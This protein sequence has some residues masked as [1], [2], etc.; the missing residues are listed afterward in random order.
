MTGCPS[1]VQLKRLLAGDLP[2]PECSALESHIQQCPPCQETL[3]HLTE[4][5]VVQ[6]GEDGPGSSQPGLL[7]LLEECQEHSTPHQCDTEP[8]PAQSAAGAGDQGLTSIASAP[9]MPGAQGRLRHYE[10]L[11]EIGQGGHGSV[12][13]AFDRK[14]QRLVAIKILAPPLADIPRARQCFVREARAAAAVSSEFTVSVYAVEELPTPFLVMEHIEGPTLQQKLDQQGPLE[15]HEVLR[16]GRQIAEGLAAAH[17]RGLIHRDIKPAN[18]LLEAGQTARISDFGLARAADDAG[19]TQSGLISGTPLYM[20]PEQA[21]EEEV[22]HRTDLFSL[23]SVLYAMCTGLPPFPAPTSLAVLQR[24]CEETPRPIRD[25]NPNIPSWLCDL[26]TRLHAKKPADRYASAREVADLLGRRWPDSSQA[27]APGG[28]RWSWILGGGA[29]GLGA[30]LLLG[31]ILLRPSANAARARL[32]PAEQDA[33]QETPPDSLP[34]HCRNSLGM[35]FVRVPRGKAWLGGGGGRPGTREITIP[36]DFYL[37]K[38]EVTQEEWQKVMGS[39]PSQFSR[40]GQ[41]S[42]AVK[43]ISGEDLKRFPVEQISYSDIQRFLEQVNQREKEAG[44]IYRLP[45][46]VEWEYACRGGPMADQAES[47]CHFYFETPTNQLRPNL[48]NF[49]NGLQRTSKVG[50]YPPNR[51]GLHDMHGNVWEWT[52]DAGRASYGSGWMV[53]GGSWKEDSG[54]CQATS[55]HVYA[56][57]SRLR[58]LRLLRGRDEK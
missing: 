2:L 28:R 56:G 44:W 36:F 5:S 38:Y 43:D 25:I 54:T 24:V 41:S 55:H 32:T 52:S 16:L 46:G 51:L 49:N 14:L 10:I 30:L 42:A 4:D 57:R 21:Q 45:R 27:V 48:A 22:D 7:R 6:R 11:K 8:L 3:E 9:L 1:P 31:L 58:G 50:S 18:I 23:G 40:M 35:E 13:K 12:F 19:L 26:I 39:N 29:I 47:A 17:S 53:W 34:D 20:A 37:G 33:S 15:L